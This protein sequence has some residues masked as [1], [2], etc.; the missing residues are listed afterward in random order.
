MVTPSLDNSGLM[1]DEQGLAQKASSLSAHP[2]PDN[3]DPIASTITEQSTSIAEA[4]ALLQKAQ[5]SAPPLVQLP[6]EPPASIPGLTTSQTDHSALKTTIASA[7]ATSEPIK[8]STTPAIVFT[9]FPKLPLELR[10]MIWREALLI[11]QVIS[12]GYSP[13]E[14]LYFEY[15][16]GETIRP[17]GSRCILNAVSQEARREALDIQE[18]LSWKSPPEQA[19]YRNVEADVL[20]VDVDKNLNERTLSHVIAILQR[21]S[22]GVIY[23]RHP[24]LAFSLAAYSHLMKCP[25]LFLPNLVKHGAEEIFV[26]VGS[27]MAFRS[28]NVVFTEPRA[29]PSAL[30]PAALSIVASSWGELEEF[31]RE[32]IRR[33]K[34]EKHEAR[35]DIIARGYNPDA[36]LYRGN[37]GN[38]DT[39]RFN[40]VKLVEATTYD[41]LNSC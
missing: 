3:A 6:A 20:W 10:R 1:A 39:W 2:L 34:A 29:L 18:R 5:G 8:S 31:F 15:P 30:I 9:L 38:V 33:A 32:E 17:S 40:N 37:F 11:P 25:S 19:I 41:E 13:Q 26:V 12:I 16:S 35:E 24:K 4:I 27:V 28:Q 23:P 22:G 21:F 36:F 7:T 14:V